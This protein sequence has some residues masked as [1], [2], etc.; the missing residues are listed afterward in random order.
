MVLM[1]MLLLA[2][3]PAWAQGPFDWGKDRILLTGY[4]FVGTR[5]PVGEETEVFGF[6]PILLIRPANRL[7]IEVE[8]ELE[9]AATRE[10][11]VKREAVLEKTL[12]YAQLD[13]VAHDNLT[14]ILGR[15]LIPFGVFTEKLHP[16]WINKLPTA[17][18]M[19]GHEGLLPV[20][21]V[22]LQLRGGALS[23]KGVKLNY[24]V[25]LSTGPQVQIGGHGAEEEEEEHEEEAE[26]EEETEA[27]QEIGFKNSWTDNNNR[28]AFGGRLGLSPRS[29]FEVGGSFFRGAYDDDRKFNLTY[30]GADAEYRTELVEIRGEYVRRTQ[31]IADGSVTLNGVYAQGALKLS[32]IPLMFFNPTELVVRYGRLDGAEAGASS[33]IAVGFNYA[34]TSRSFIRL[35]VTSDKASG[36]AEEEMGAAPKRL[37]PANEEATAVGSKWTNRVYVTFTHGF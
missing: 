2:A 11:R 25:F 30:A 4:T 21:Q 13:I 26:E 19:Y 27:L 31:D 34:L 8:P 37:R 5:A 22:G 15:Y 14:I 7:L 23:S 17:P 16:A 9:V 20:N 12:E 10:G 24:A 28:P 18:I 32:F 36:E 33:Q 1:L 3:L 6:N 35:A 29:R